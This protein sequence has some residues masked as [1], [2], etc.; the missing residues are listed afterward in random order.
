MEGRSGGQSRRQSNEYIHY[1]L[2]LD[3]ICSLHTSP[4]LIQSML[5]VKE[6]LPSTQKSSSTANHLHPSLRKSRPSDQK[7]LPFSQHF[8]RTQETFSNCG[9]PCT[10]GKNLV[11][12]SD[13]NWRGLHSSGV[14]ANMIS[15][16]NLS[17]HDPT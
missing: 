2:A 16:E 7:I 9:L 11:V 14:L 4:V 8:K 13:T 10:H 6:G 17:S 5:A 12:S 1:T 15:Y 3:I